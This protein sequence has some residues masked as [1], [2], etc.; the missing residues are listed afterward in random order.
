MCNIQRTYLSATALVVTLLMS[1]VASA[2]KVSDFKTAS[3]KK[4]CEA[5]PYSSE[6]SMCKTLSSKKD[7]ACKNFSCLLDKTTKLVE[8]LQKKR[9]NLKE[10]KERKNESAARDLEREIKR[11]EDAID[12]AKDEATGR[13]RQ[14]DACIKARE[15][16]QKHFDVVRSK[17]EDERDKALKPFIAILAPHF[18]SEKEAH[19]RPIEEVRRARQNCEKVLKI[20][21]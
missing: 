10:A 1:G 4:G 7:V 18:E 11:L 19:K 6:Q 20:S 15:D 9:E 17:V 2:D 13:I 14:A 21:Y 16:V 8:K 5:V 3:E 12:E